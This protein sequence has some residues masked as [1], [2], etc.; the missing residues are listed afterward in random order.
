MLSSVMHKKRLDTLK[1]LVTTVLRSKKLSLSELGREMDLPIQER[2][3]LKRVDRF[4]GN[5]K[6]YKE[7]EA[8]CKILTENAIGNKIRPDIIVDWSSIP[9]TT[10]HVLRA[11]LTAKGRAITLYEEVHPEKKQENKKVHNKFLCKL[12]SL[13]PEGCRPIII[14]NGG[15][16][17][18]WF[19]EV[20]KLGWDYLGRIR[21]GS[22][23]KFLQMNSEEWKNCATLMKKA[24]STPKYIGKVVLCKRYSITTYLYLFKGKRKKR[25]ELS[26]PRGR[27]CSANADPRKAAREPWLL[28]TSLCKGYFMPKKMVKKYAMRM[29]IEEGF[30]DLKS[31][32]YGFGFENA[33]SKKRARI[34]ILLLIAMLAAYIAWLTGWVAEKS[35]LHYQFQSNTIKTRR[36]LSLFFLGCQVIKKKIKISIRML[37]AAVLEAS[38]YAAA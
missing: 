10:H 25:K 34:E 27:S 16:H 37:E 13:L 18:D 29:Q 36:V 15:F 9:N 5:E 4:L 3:C 2:S 26:L 32:R 28:A 33:Y 20:V 30:R 17:N 21:A 23:K 38:C 35:G 24:S 8:I 7:R 6:L 14:T 11:S 31:S 1:I 12:K 19:K 22:G